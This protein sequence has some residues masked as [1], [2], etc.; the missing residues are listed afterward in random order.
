MGFKSGAATREGVSADTKKGKYNQFVMRTMRRRHAQLVRPLWRK[1]EMPMNGRNS[2]AAAHR[3]A[4]ASG[5]ACCTAADDQ[6]NSCASN[7]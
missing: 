2:A 6:I 7:R 5:A 1:P 3:E 4:W